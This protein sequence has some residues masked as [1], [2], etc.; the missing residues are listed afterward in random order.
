MR[1][2]REILAYHSSLRQWYG[3]RCPKVA[4]ERHRLPAHIKDPYCRLGG[5]EN[6]NT[7]KTHAAV[8]KATYVLGGFG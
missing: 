1:G 7:N 3:P 6:A 4:L 2:S 8:H 5:L